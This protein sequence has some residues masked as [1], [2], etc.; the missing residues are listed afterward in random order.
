MQR[1]DAQAGYFAGESPRSFPDEAVLLTRTR[2]QASIEY[3]KYL[4]DCV[5]K[6]KEENARACVASEPPAPFRASAAGAHS[7]DVDMTDSSPGPSPVLTPNAITFQP[8]MLSPSLLAGS[9][10]DHRG[11]LSSA[12]GGSRGNSAT[13]SPALDPQGY[14]YAQS[15]ASIA[16]SALTSPALPPQRDRDLDQ[17]AT[18]ALLML[19]QTDRRGSMVRGMSVK[20]LLSS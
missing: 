14:E 20:D 17:E 5:A 2:C 15:L 13:T 7:S 6:L 10:R 18:A 4:E 1:G 19:N 11:S 8:P 3:V 12:P 9:Y 16:G